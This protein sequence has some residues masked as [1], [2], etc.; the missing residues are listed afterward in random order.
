MTL[1]A[2]KD[3]YIGGRMVRR[4]QFYQT[5]DQIGKRHLKNGMAELPAVVVKPKTAKPQKTKVVGPEGT[6]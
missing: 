3:I 2:K 1:K 5:T 4:G 6:K